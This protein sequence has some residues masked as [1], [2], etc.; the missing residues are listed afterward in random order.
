MQVLIWQF[1]DMPRAILIGWKN[2][3]LFNLNYFS[4]QLLLKTYFS[5]WHK[6]QYPY[7]RVFEFWKNTEVFIF[8]MMSRIIGA[9][10]RTFIIIIGIIS[11]ILIIILGLIIFLGW[12][13]LPALLVFGLFFGISLMF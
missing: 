2:F 7:E 5:H 13:I 4:V 1:F 10:V 9:I 3:L 11:E 6:Y 12:L 8:N